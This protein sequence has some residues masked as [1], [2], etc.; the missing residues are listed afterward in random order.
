MSD[1]NNA[2]CSC[3]G[4]ACLDGILFIFVIWA[5]LYGLPTPWGKISIDIF[6]PKFEIIK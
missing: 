2:S 5:L 3:G 1:N 6:P 4:M